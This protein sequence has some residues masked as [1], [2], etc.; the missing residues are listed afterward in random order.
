M[1][2]KK[3]IAAI[4]S[5]AMLCASVVTAAAIENAGTTGTTDSTAAAQVEDR[6]QE[7][8]EDTNDTDTGNNGGTTS[9][10]K[11]PVEEQ[12]MINEEEYATLTAEQKAKFY[13]VT[14]DDGI[15]A[16]INNDTGEY[17]ISGTSYIQRNT[18]T[19][20]LISVPYNNYE[21]VDILINGE[22]ATLNPNGDNTA[23]TMAYDVEDY[24]LGELSIEMKWHTEAKGIIDADEYATLTDE[25]KANFIKMNIAPEIAVSYTNEYGT[26]FFADGYYINKNSW[27]DIYFCILPNIY[28][29]HDIMI[30]GE[31]VNSTGEFA[32]NANYGG[33]FNVSNY[34]GNELN[35][36]LTEDINGLANADEYAAM[37]E[38]R[39]NSYIKLNIDENAFISIQDKVTGE[40]ITLS[41]GIYVAKTMYYI[42][43]GVYPD[44]YANNDVYVNGV[45][46]DVELSGDGYSNYGKKYY[47]G[48]YTGKE[49]TVTLG[50]KQQTAPAENTSLSTDSVPNVVPTVKTD[51]A[52]EKKI[53]NTIVKANKPNLAVDV[54]ETGVTPEMLSK[55]AGSNKVQTLTAKYSN[56]FMVK[57]TKEDIDVGNAET[58]DFSV[59]GNNFISR[60]QIAK[61]KI[62]R[63]SER[64]IQ[65]D[66]NKKGE[67]TGVDKV[68]VKTRTNIGDDGKT[69]VIYEL[70]D[71]K[72]KK[73]GEYTVKARGFVEFETDHLGQFVIVVR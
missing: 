65:L 42:Y 33:F 60:S 29:Q 57:I 67:F 23:C 19:W 47:I 10:G 56:G 14:V 55:L 15:Y 68:T 37:P 2:F 38:V 59:S 25:Q 26:V 70:V 49:L 53:I 32:G 72:L 40:T 45:K 73:A 69:A 62:L 58:L 54:S 71:G 41:D 39:K 4:A 61:N 44:I 7:Q 52:A 27:D 1:N 6:L 20:I 18:F 34:T 48:N 11:V 5:V 50:E 63:N 31:I 66:F 43:I 35:F 28:A 3:S 22:K 24:Q 30:N 21:K 12:G 13:K 51:V 36:Y 64:I 46:H 9:D 17:T 8:A 16:C